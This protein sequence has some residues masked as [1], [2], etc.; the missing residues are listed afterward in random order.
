MSKGAKGKKYR[1]H[2][3]V[4]NH[5]TTMAIATPMRMP[6]NVPLVVDIGPPRVERAA[7]VNRNYVDD[8]ESDAFS[9]GALRLPGWPGRKN[10]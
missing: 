10:K 4:K 9:L 2:H 8:F 7:C 6:T 1:Y 5:Q 3:A